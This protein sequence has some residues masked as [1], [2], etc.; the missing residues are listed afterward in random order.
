MI[1]HKR[2]ES[3]FGECLL[4]VSEV[5]TFIAAAVCL[6][7]CIVGNVWCLLNK[8]RPIKSTSG[9]LTGHLFHDFL[10]ALL[11]PPTGRV[12]YFRG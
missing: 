3:V 7:K 9:N 5:G 4:Q 8:T 10:V 1:I 11:A 6:L 12:D 2:D